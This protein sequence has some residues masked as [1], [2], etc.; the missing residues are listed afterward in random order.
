MDTQNINWEKFREGAEIKHLNEDE[1]QVSLVKLEP[2]VK[3][4]EHA[5]ETAEWIYVLG[6]SFS[7][8]AGEYAAGHF[9]TS[10]K[11]SKHATQSGA[12]GCELLLI[13]LLPVG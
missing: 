8:A 11:G 2:N 1:V 12:E 7:D 6:G 3:F 4:D 9:V 10:A 5:H 13:K